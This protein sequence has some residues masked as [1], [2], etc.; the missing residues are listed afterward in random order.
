MVT[1]PFHNGGRERNPSFGIHLIDGRCNCLTCGWNGTINK[2]AEEIT[3]EKHWVERNTKYN[4]S[5][6]R[7]KPIKLKTAK[8]TYL[9]PRYVQ[10][11]CSNNKLALDYLANRGVGEVTN[12]PVGYNKQHNSL[13]L[14]IRDLLGRYIYVKERSLTT[15]HFYNTEESDKANHLFGLYE[16]TQANVAEV[17]VCESEIDALTIW[18]RGGFAVAIGSATISKAQIKL[19]HQ[20][21]IR[22]VIDGLDRDIAGRKGWLNLKELWTG[23]TRETKW[24]IKKKDINDTTLEEFTSKIVVDKPKNI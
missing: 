17:W 15:K 24:G 16:C 9:D 18:A 8:Q 19:L 22:S 20:A 3:G 14:F 23:F 4:K 6:I 11:L 13:V 12:F 21:G 2:L 7:R 10:A 1:C 5:V